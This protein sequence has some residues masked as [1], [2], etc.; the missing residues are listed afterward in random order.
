MLK[1]SGRIFLDSR[2][3]GRHRVH[4]QVARA[5]GGAQ[6]GTCGATMSN[7][8]ADAPASNGNDGL[9]VYD[10]GIVVS[11]VSG[12]NVFTI[13]LQQTRHMSTV[14]FWN[15]VSCCQDRSV[16]AAIR[17]GSN[18]SWLDN[19][20]CATLTDGLEQTYQCDILGRYA[21]LVQQSGFM[22][23]LELEV[24][25]D[26]CTACAANTY[27]AGQ[28]NAACDLCPAR[29]TSLARSCAEEQCHCDAGFCKHGMLCVQCETDTFRVSV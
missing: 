29:S 20:L 1:L 2:Q 23:F 6:G 26:T 7:P 3:H 25:G 27:K 18:V 21:F 16:G 22:N 28:G 15:R 19:A 14:K 11:S 24:F 13:D 17:I 10:S 4:V 9:H 12:L 5:C 8:R